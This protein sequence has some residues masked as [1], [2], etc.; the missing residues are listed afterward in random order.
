MPPSV[1]GLPEVKD[2]IQLFDHNV[3]LLVSAIQETS[4]R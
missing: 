3:R 2:Y 4:S 1:G